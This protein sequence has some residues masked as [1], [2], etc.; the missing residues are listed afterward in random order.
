M[1]FGWTQDEAAL[2]DVAATFG[3]D[4]LNVGFE[5]RDRAGEFGREL[6]RKCADFGVLGLPLPEEY[7]GTA[8]ELP[9]VV[10]T[11]EALGYGCRDNGLLFAL[12]AQLWSVEMPILIFGNEEQRVRYLPSL[13]QGDLFG[14]HAVTEPGAGSDAHSLRTKATR[15][16]SEYVLNGSKAFITSAPSS[17][18]FLVLA[19]LDPSQGS[20]A[21]AAFLVDRDSE[22]LTIGPPYEKIGLHTAPM[23]EV[24]FAD[25]GV[26]DTAMLGRPGAGAT[27][28]ATAMEWERSFILAPALG[29]MKRQIEECIRYA[30]SRTQFGRPI[31]KNESL[32]SKLVDMQMRLELSQLLTYRTAWMKQVGRRLTREP[33]QIK[34]LVSESWVRNSLDALQ[35]HGGYGFMTESGIGRDLTAA[36]ASRIYSG[37]SEMQRRIIASLMGL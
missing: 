18:V 31:G 32:A 5:E 27:V 25:C 37:T 21:L 28:F 3:R 26:P 20:R 24:A 17:D 23:A 4:V 13:A 7:G 34:L 36:L 1:D 12:G 8:L 16:G 30:R 10:L 9:A 35:I 11:L 6:W 19:T 15:R 29:A 14:A 33:S 22:G 2:A